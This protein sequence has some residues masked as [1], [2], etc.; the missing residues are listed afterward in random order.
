MI[1]QDF[2]ERMSQ[3][4]AKVIAELLGFDTSQKLEYL[5]EYFATM[6]IDT[7]DLLESPLED[8]MEELISREDL[9]ISHLELVANL[10]QQKALVYYEQEYDAF[11]HN[12][13]KKAIALL[14]HVDEEMDTFSVQRRELLDAM[15]RDVSDEEYDLSL[16]HI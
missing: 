6:S 1:K 2:I 13:M 16:I 3:E 4:L 8:L 11:G 14:E 9:Q 5:N 10:I 7:M 12:L 15:K